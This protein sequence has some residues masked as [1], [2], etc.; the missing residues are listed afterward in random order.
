MQ[1]PEGRVARIG[2]IFMGTYSHYDAQYGNASRDVEFRDIDREHIHSEMVGHPLLY[3]IP[4]RGDDRST[5]R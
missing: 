3:E 1:L 5:G 2:V 4:W